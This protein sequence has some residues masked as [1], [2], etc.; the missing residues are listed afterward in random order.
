MPI[1]SETLC[2]RNQSVRVLAFISVTFFCSAIPSYG[3]QQEQIDSL[4]AKVASAIHKSFKKTSDQQ[5]IM[6]VISEPGTGP[7]E[8]GAR[9]ANEFRSALAARGISLMT[10]AKLQQT[11]DEE[12]IPLVA[13]RDPGTLTCVASDAGATVIVDGTIQRSGDELQLVTFLRAK[14]AK[15]SFK[16]NVDFD[17]TPELAELQDRLVPSPPVRKTPESKTNIPEAGKR[18]YTKP[19]CLYC[20]TPQYSDRAFAM[21]EQGTVVLDVVIAPDGKAHSVA[22]A[23]GLSC[24]LNGRAVD[25]VEN[26]RFRPANGPDGK[27]AAVHMLIEVDFRVY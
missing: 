10:S 21:K 26:W 1:Y 9:I 24:D 20:P 7:T 4:A 23:S 17:R 13:L 8:L 3:G 16:G 18:G 19:S 6:V 25:A 15:V 11:Q 14:N 22:I 5:L 2:C 27:P 12:K